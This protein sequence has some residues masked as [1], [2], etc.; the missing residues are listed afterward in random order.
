MR[1][2]L[3]PQAWQ[4]LIRSITGPLLLPAGDPFDTLRRPATNRYP[5][6]PP[7]AIARCATPTDVAQVINFSR[8]Y[9]VG[10]AV[11][12]AGHSFAD[13]SST[14]GLLIETGLMCTVAVDGDAPP[15]EQAP[16]SRRSTGHYMIT[17][18]QSPPAVDQSSASPV[19]LWVAGWE[20]LVEP[21]ASPATA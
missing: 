9:G 4:Q 3:P 12:G 15:L 8:R 14:T 19:S 17:K 5:T 13:H 20:C 2:S 11:R 1:S 21:M 6:A 10:I 7:Q 18:P 16:V